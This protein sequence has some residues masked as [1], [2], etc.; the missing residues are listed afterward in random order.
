MNTATIKFDSFEN[1]KNQDCQERIIK[2]RKALGDEIVILGH[3]YQNE[4]VY[5]HA[6]LSGDSLKLAK[7]VADLDAKY[8]VF[9]GVN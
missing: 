2:A 9:L 7:Y 4:E 5:R 6:D 3:H 1:L 8:I